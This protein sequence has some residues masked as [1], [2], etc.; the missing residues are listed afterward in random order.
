MGSIYILLTKRNI[1][2]FILRILAPEEAAASQEHVVN[3]VS[4]EKK[5]LDRCHS[6][7]KDGGITAFKCPPIN[8]VSH[9]ANPDVWREEHKSEIMKKSPQNLFVRHKGNKISA[10]NIPQ[11][12]NGKVENSYVKKDGIIK[13]LY[14]YANSDR[15]RKIMLLLENCRLLDICES[16]IFIR[17][18]LKKK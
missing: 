12:L 6:S 10:I 3:D 13:T 5:D 1:D 7:K 17:S 2:I 9:E 14:Y 16:A 8:F 18:I 15:G 4:P 11:L